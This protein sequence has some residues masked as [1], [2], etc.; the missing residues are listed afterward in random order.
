MGF[1]VK[2][3]VAAAQLARWWE[4]GKPACFG[5]SGSSSSAPE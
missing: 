3:M 1:S 5:E 2:G 4:F